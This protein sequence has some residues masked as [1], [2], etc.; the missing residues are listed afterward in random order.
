MTF[1][2]LVF[3]ILETGLGALGMFLMYR[4]AIL[5]LKNGKT[6]TS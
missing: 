6:K 5:A 2:E 4:I 1:E 3:K